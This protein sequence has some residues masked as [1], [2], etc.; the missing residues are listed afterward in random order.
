MSRAKVLVIFLITG[1]LALLS[2]AAIALAD[3]GNVCPSGL[4]GATFNQV[5]VFDSDDTEFSLTLS[6]EAVIY[7]K[8]VTP[9]PS[10]QAY[11]G[12][13][14]A[15]SGPVSIGIL[16]V[17]NGTIH[18][19]FTLS[20]ANLFTDFHTVVISVEPV[21]D[22]DPAPSTVKPYVKTINAE[23][24]AHIRHL[25]Y[26]WQGN[27]AYTAGPHAGTPKGIVV[28]LREQVALALLHAN[29]AID[30]D[31]LAGIQQHAE[32]VVNII[33]GGAGQDLDGVGG[34][35]NPGDKGPGVLGYADDTIKHGQFILAINRSGVSD[36]Y[37][38]Q[39]VDSGQ[40]TKIW[41][42]QARERVMAAIGATELIVARAAVTNA[43]IILDWALNGV[44]TANRN[45]RRIIGE[46]GAVQAYAASQDIGTYVL[47]TRPITET[48]QPTSTPPPTPT[49]KPPETGDSSVPGL[50]FPG[51]ILG[52]ILLAIGGTVLYGLS[53]RRTSAL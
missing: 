33:D 53:R 30:Q 37:I 17:S 39:A 19:N 38:Q 35:Q 3:H 28:G 11:E 23:A 31:S 7:L 18:Q 32:H 8:S 12:W 24:L 5:C 21:P 48:E 27:P 50:A 2:P 16:N 20:G 15:D 43:S 10:N 49:A 40:Q 45:P 41:A 9:L 47:N 13:L 4:G 26:S 52:L 14:V 22:P 46:G 44:S 36:E 34:A 25:L 29:L 6:D 42:E 1:L 51:L